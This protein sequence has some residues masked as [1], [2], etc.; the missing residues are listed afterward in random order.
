MDLLEYEIIVTD[1]ETVRNEYVKTKAAIADS[2]EQVSLPILST[3]YHRCVLDEAHRIRNGSAI[4]ITAAAINKIRSTYRI[5]MTGTPFNNEYTDVHG[6][7]EFLRIPPWN[8]QQLFISSFM[9]KPNGQRDVKLLDG[10]RNAILSLTLL[11]MMVRY[12]HGDQYCPPDGPPESIFPEIECVPIVSELTPTAGERA[13]Q[14]ATRFQ[15]DEDYKEENKDRGSDITP[16][17]LFRELIKARLAAIHPELPSARYG[18]F[19]IDDAIDDQ[20]WLLVEL[21]C[22][23]P[24]EPPLRHNSSREAFR[25]MMAASPGRWRSTKTTRA[26]QSIKEHLGKRTGKIL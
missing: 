1:F 23:T 17:E 21:A 14:E 16:S 3:E 19:G 5:A 4:T 25:A 6:L 8:N 10:P 9:K 26:V 7:I 11:S 18:E 13:D 12:V 20:H 22:K 24:S 15:W 2:R